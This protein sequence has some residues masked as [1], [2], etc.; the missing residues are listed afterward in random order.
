MFITAVDFQETI[1]A[2]NLCFNT[3]D[4]PMESFEEFS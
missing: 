3:A 1:T 4:A 2:K